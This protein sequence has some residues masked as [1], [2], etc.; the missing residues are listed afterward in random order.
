M[1]IAERNDVAINVKP[2]DLSS[3]VFLFSGSSLRRQI[4][5]PCR[6]RTD[7]CL[8][9]AGG[10]QSQIGITRLQLILISGNMIDLINAVQLTQWLGVPLPS[11]VIR[12]L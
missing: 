4:D 11:V 1:E 5:H 3:K 12:V 8:S 10:G 7:Q 6:L 2:M 9:N